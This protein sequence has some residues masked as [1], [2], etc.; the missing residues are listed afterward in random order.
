MPW[1][2]SVRR[3]DRRESGKRGARIYTCSSMPKARLEEKKGRAGRRGDIAKWGRTPDE[4][5]DDGRL[6]LVELC[7]DSDREGE[8]SVADH[9]LV[10]ERRHDRCEGGKAKGSR[11]SV[12][13]YGLRVKTYASTAP[14]GVRSVA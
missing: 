10:V 9:L 14:F 13:V 12:Y 2:E 11:R 6:G 4:L 3:A 5:P 8:V 1:S 7:V